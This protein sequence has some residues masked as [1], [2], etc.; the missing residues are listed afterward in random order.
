MPKVYPYQNILHQFLICEENSGFFAED[1]GYKL[2]LYKHVIGSLSPER[3]IQA[4]PARSHIAIALKTIILLGSLAGRVPLIPLSLKFEKELSALSITLAVA[5]FIVFSN[6]IARNSINSV[7]KLATHVGLQEKTRFK[8]LD[9]CKKA[10]LVAFSLLNALAAISSYGVLSWDYNKNQPYMLCLNATDLILPVF[11]LYTLLDHLSAFCK[12]DPTYKRLINLQN[13]LCRHID[14]RISSHIQ[15]FDFRTE[16]LFIDITRS[17]DTEAKMSYFFHNVFTNPSLLDPE[18]NQCVKFSRLALSTSLATALTGIQVMWVCFLAYIGLQ[19]LNLEDAA[20]VTILSYICLCNIALTSHY[21]FK[22]TFKEVQRFNP[23]ICK[24]QP[25]FHPLDYIAPMTSK[26]ISLAAFLLSACSFAPAMQMSQ[27]YLPKNLLLPSTMLY[28][29]SFTMINYLPMKKTLQNLA[30]RLFKLNIHPQQQK[31][32]DLY[33]R[34]KD[35]RYLFQN[36]D[37]KDFALFVL[38]TQGITPIRQLMQ[39]HHIAK[40]ELQVL[41][42]R[43]EFKEIVI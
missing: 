7:N 4:P 15:G 22:S 33:Q 41:L 21:I 38:N 40:L 37:T 6:F 28:G 43:Y 36:A 20:L 24:K 12:K 9:T 18:P 39:K 30:L 3:S 1:Q 8:G 32:L 16:D 5:N 27:D 35:A 19:R 11:C 13:D 25:I 31:Y 29:L 23:L 17:V 26:L 42:S 14:E 34:L 10:C 2:K